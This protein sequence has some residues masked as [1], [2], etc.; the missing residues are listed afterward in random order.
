MTLAVAGVLTWTVVSTYGSSSGLD[1]AR[2]LPTDDPCAVV[3]EQALSRMDGEVGSWHT[4]VYSNGCNWTVTIADEPDVDLYFRRSVPMSESDAERAEDRGSEDVPR[5]TDEFYEMIVDEATDPSYLSDGSSVLD[6]EER[7]LRYGDESV[8]VLTEVSYGLSSG[9]GNQRATL[10]VRE[11][12]V[13]S[14]L[15]FTLYS[16][17]TVDADEA[18]DLITEMVA[19]SFFE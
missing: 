7:A 19:D 9:A 13:V 5:D 17:T 8:L 10:V 6:T 12:D 18:E 15:S 3:D 2:G 11:G 14:Q 1:P 4:T 16:E